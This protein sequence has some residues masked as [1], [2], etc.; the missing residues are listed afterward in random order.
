MSGVVQFFFD[1]TLVIIMMAVGLTIIRLL[2]FTNIA[3]AQVPYNEDT[4]DAVDYFMEKL[5]ERRKPMYMVMHYDTQMVLVFDT[6]TAVFKT[7]REGGFDE[8]RH[9]LVFT[10]EELNDFGYT[11][12]D[13]EYMWVSITYDFKEGIRKD[14]V[15]ANN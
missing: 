15:S 6:A 14:D 7:I 10:E 8:S 12:D 2:F 1:V 9:V 4:N 11:V 13:D 5:E 3:I